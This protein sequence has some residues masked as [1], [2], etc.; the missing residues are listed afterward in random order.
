MF[1][2]GGQRGFFCFSVMFSL[3]RHWYLVWWKRVSGQNAAIQHGSIKQLSL[4]SIFSRHQ[5]DIWTQYFGVREMV[6]ANRVVTGS[7][8]KQSWGLC[9]SANC[10]LIIIHP[11]L[12]QRKR[13]AWGP[14]ANAWPTHAIGF[15]EDQISVSL[16]FLDWC[17]WCGWAMFGRA[18]S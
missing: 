3:W 10:L 16:F 6:P 1:N 5:V 12:M 7:Y 2:F 8:I 14:Q 15:S 4:C 17:K 13:S 11:E 18:V 9:I